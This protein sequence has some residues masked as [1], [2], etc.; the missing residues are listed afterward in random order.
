MLSEAKSKQFLSN[1]GVLFTTEIEVFSVDDAVSAADEIGYPVAIK[2]CADAIS[3]KSERGMVKLNVRSSTEVRDASTTLLGQ[4]KPEDGQASLLVAKMES[5][6]R[7]L[8]A[9]VVRDEQF[10][11]FVMPGM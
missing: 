5:G 7:E 10:G 8:I 1:Y 3:H 11:S 6:R 9:G 2:I 4:L